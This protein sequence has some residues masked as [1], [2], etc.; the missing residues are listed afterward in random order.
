MAGETKNIWASVIPRFKK[1]F[2]PRIECG[3]G[4]QPL[5]LKL[6]AALD[7]VW[8]GYDDLIVGNNCWHILQVK[9]KMGA[10]VMYAEVGMQSTTSDSAEVFE[11]YKVRTSNFYALIDGAHFKSTE[12]CEECGEV[13]RKR[14]LIGAYKTLCDRCFIKWEEERTSTTA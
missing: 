13:G 9:E 10:L 12:I 14:F 11:N 2:M 7:K 8:D 1:G 6:C 4:W 5:V 3:P